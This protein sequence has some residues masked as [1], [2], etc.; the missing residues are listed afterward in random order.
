MVFRLPV[1]SRKEVL[2]EFRKIGII[3]VEVESEES[4]NEIKLMLA[5]IDNLNAPDFYRNDNLKLYPLPDSK[6]NSILLVKA[7]A[8]ILSYAENGLIVSDD[9]YDIN[10]GITK[11]NGFLMK[12]I[13]DAFDTEDL[14]EQ[15]DY[16]LEPS[17]DEK[18]VLEKV[19][20]VISKCDHLDEDGK[21]YLESCFQSW[22]ELF[23]FCHV[24]NHALTSKKKLV[25]LKDV[26]SLM[27][28]NNSVKSIATVIS[29][30]YPEIETK[31]YHVITSDCSR[32]QFPTMKKMEDHF[33]RS[34]HGYDG[35]GTGKYDDWVDEFKCKKR[36]ISLLEEG[37]SKKTVMDFIK[38]RYPYREDRPLEELNEIQDEVKMMEWLQNSIR[39]VDH[40][41]DGGRK[42]REKYCN[43]REM[44]PEPNCSEVVFRLD[45]MTREEVLETL[46]GIG[47]FEIEMLRRDWNDQ[48]TN[49][50]STNK[51][52]V[53]M[54]NQNSPDFTH[55]SFLVLKEGE[56]KIDGM[57]TIETVDGIKVK[58]RSAYFGLS[59]VGYYSD[60]SQLFSTLKKIEDNFECDMYWFEDDHHYRK[61]I[62]KGCRDVGEHQDERAKQ[63][64][65]KYKESVKVTAPLKLNPNCSEV[66]FM[67][68][69]LTREEA[70]K[71][72]AEIGL[73]EIT[74]KYAS[75]GGKE[76]EWTGLADK[77]NE[78]IPN[79]SSSAGNFDVDEWQDGTCIHGGMNLR[80][81]AY[82]TMLKIKR[83]F[84][85]GRWEDLN[86]CDADEFRQ[87]Y[88]DGMP[89]VKTAMDDRTKKFREEKV[90]HAIKKIG[91]E[92]NPNCSEIV[93]RLP[94]ITKEEA[95]AAL[96][97][98][99]II[100]ISNHPEG[101]YPVLVD[102]DN[103][104]VPNMDSKFG[105]AMLVIKTWNDGMIVI[106]GGINIECSAFPTLKK[107]QDTFPGNK[108]EEA[109]GGMMTGELEEWMENGMVLTKRQEKVFKDDLKTPG[110]ETIKFR[111]EVV[112]PAM[113]TMEVELNP[114]CSE[115]VF[116][117]RGFKA[118][119][120]ALQM[121]NKI[122]IFEIEVVDGDFWDI[123]SGDETTTKMLSDVD[124]PNLPDFANQATLEIKDNLEFFGFSIVG[125]EHSQAQL[126]S[127]MKKIEKRFG[128]DWF[129]NDGGSDE[130]YRDWISKGCKAV[131]SYQDEKGMKMAKKYEIQLKK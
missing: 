21:S 62:L 126:F 51:M 109:M 98:I 128:G 100:E 81:Y 118:R 22:G 94:G 4:S 66:V 105:C 1:I 82:P 38:K 43:F 125:K 16:W 88:I 71:T 87:W 129:G 85:E 79:F 44:E 76:R 13:L 67:L 35:G 46:N 26:T 84:P 48:V 80:D 60:Q 47:I 56:W 101:K 30:K 111:K 65:N 93:F 52:L 119:E 49:P 70:V 91:L 123:S 97:G 108:W 45:A 18:K 19:H 34:W 17:E 122:G 72:L 61:W 110:K 127:T 32:S 114:N 59:I 25:I 57:E 5:D 121:L 130:N 90:E 8:S 3:E 77:D 10:V 73:F 99:G 24:E 103:P 104:L 64:I 95:I 89:A 55:R 14:V 20:D 112:E 39:L 92:L 74:I 124:N 23:V 29:N 116:Q 36:V 131:P 75:S 37:N 117:L 54:D 33:G 40:Q 15:Y 106:H 68:A 58:D 6:Y 41:G 78:L 53:D 9:G 7:V 96:K 42:K 69:G 50:E 113:K 12:K 31:M 83:K 102:R 11:D 107:I 28:G 120:E 27:N 2:E 86:G 63:L 115:V